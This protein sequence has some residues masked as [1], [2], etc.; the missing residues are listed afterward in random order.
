[1]LEK[2]GIDITDGDTVGNVLEMYKTGFSILEISKV[3]GLGVEEVK[4]IID[5]Q[6]E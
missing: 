5:K 3:L 4:S 6:G 1:M 2:E